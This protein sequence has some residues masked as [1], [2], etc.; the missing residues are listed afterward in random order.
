ME[1]S[2]L[3]SICWCKLSLP[4]S[5][6]H[7]I[8]D[9]AFCCNNYSI[10]FY[11][12]YQSPNKTI[13]N[14]LFMFISCVDGCERFLSWISKLFWFCFV[15]LK[16]RGAENIKLIS[17]EFFM[18]TD[19]FHSESPLNSPKKFLKAHYIFVSLVKN[20][21]FFGIFDQNCRCIFLNFLK[22]EYSCAWFW[23]LL[24]PGMR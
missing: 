14:Q 10:W 19:C 11:W 3:E 9:S 8:I 6:G 1:Q 13:N 7:Q 5:E 2:R 17:R 21:Y 16:L 20:N 24:S 22:S 15:R 18:K 12:S 4:C 23:H